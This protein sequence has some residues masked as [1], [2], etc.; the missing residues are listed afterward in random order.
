[1]PTV[2]HKRVAEAIRMCDIENQGERVSFPFSEFR[3]VLLMNDVFVDIRAIRTRWTVFVSKGIIIEVGG[4]FGK[5]LLDI[6][7]FNE[8]FG[9]HIDTR[10]HTHTHTHTYAS[11]SVKS[12]GSE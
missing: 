9:Y 8:A 5:A 7:A 3:D 4:H 10:M 6:P 2:S 11:S 12:E 1:M